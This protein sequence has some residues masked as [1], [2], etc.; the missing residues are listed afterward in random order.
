MSTI[1]RQTLTKQLMRRKNP[2][3]TQDQLFE[4][5]VQLFRQTG[6]RLQDA[7]DLVNST[8]QKVRVAEALEISTAEN[9]DD[10]TEEQPQ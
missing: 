1:I 10:N 9:S 6:L 5:G 2:D 3:L 4:L 7:Y 8:Y